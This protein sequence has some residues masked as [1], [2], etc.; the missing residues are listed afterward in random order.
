MSSRLFN[1]EMLG[2]NEIQDSGF[3]IRDSKMRRMSKISNFEP[4]S[5]SIR[6]GVP[7][8]FVNGFIHIF[9]FA[10]FGTKVNGIFLAIHSNGK[11][12]VHVHAAHWIFYH[13]AC[14]ISGVGASFGR[15]RGF[16]STEK[17]PSK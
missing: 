11:A 15:F 16:L 1:Y 4:L 9:L 12:R 17:N 6:N 10:F 13:P 7:D 5:A 2:L 14:A 3:R 8:S